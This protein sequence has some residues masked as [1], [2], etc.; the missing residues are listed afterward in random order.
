MQFSSHD[1]EITKNIVE[2]CNALPLCGHIG[3]I[4]TEP[5]SQWSWILQFR[6]KVL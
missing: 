4:Q 1:C 6:K 5:L 3:H 2:K